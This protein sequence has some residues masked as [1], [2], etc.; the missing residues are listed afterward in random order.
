VG[1]PVSPVVELACE[2]LAAMLTPALVFLVILAR[3]LRSPGEVV[4]VVYIE[5][6]VPPMLILIL[7]PF[8][9]A[10]RWP[11]VCR[12]IAARARFVAEIAILR[13]RFLC[14]AVEAL[15]IPPIAI[16]WVVG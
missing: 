16:A 13:A 7:E 1:L 14:P 11:I 10:R 4:S 5:G 8:V 12:G 3:L 6:G 2:A 15:I 9:V